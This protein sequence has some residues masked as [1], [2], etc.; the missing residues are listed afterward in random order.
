[1]ALQEE[2]CQHNKTEEKKLLL[3][4]KKNLYMYIQLMGP[5]L[6]C[7]VFLLTRQHLS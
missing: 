4:I 2:N 3:H 1:M 6:K 7:V 5:Y